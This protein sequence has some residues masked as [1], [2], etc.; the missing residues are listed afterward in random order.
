MTK[1]GYFVCDL[2]NDGI[3]FAVVARSTD[4]AK[5]M[6]HEAGLL[7]EYPKEDIECWCIP[8]A[9]IEGLPLGMVKDDR[10]ALCRGLYDYLREYECDECKMDAWVT[11]YEGRVLCEDCLWDAMHEDDDDKNR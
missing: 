3:G 8:E 11:C 4:E 10:D 7:E 5:E 6:V 2:D 9:N 1:M